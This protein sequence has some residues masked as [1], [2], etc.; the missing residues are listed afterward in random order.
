MAGFKAATLRGNADGGHKF[1]PYLVYT[2]ILKVLMF[3]KT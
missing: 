3:K 1:K 2:A